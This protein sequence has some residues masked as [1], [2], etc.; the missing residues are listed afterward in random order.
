MFHELQK[1]T[2]ISQLLT[3]H[4]QRVAQQ[5]LR[6]GAEQAMLLLAGG[7]GNVCTVTTSNI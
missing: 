4:P 7:K 6:A 2:R 3:P 5:G 1:D